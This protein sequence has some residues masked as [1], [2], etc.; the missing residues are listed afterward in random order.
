[1]IRRPITRRLRPLVTVVLAVLA[2]TALAPSSRAAGLRPT[3]LLIG[4]SN[5]YGQLGRALEADLVAQ[6]FRVVRRGKPTSG[7]ARPEFFDWFVEARRL[8]DLTHPSSVVM[9][10]GGNDGQRLR[11]RDRSLGTIRWEDEGRWRIVYETRVR[12]LMELLRGEDRRVVLLS[13]TNRAPP[14]ARERM[15]RVR[16]V[17]QQAVAG[18]DRVSY[19]DMFPYTS[20]DRGR[21][22]S[23]GRDAYGHRVIYRRGDGIHLTPEGGVE[24]A[25]RMLPALTRLL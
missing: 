14:R 15:G 19:V 11:F 3:V 16:A 21:W 20:D 10:F 1:M 23:A 5:I 12:R 4:D 18:L 22:L 9:L 24:V 13:P 8:L 2:L 6:G 25:R 17:M 7:L